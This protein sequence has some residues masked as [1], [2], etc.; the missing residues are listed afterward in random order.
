[1]A[2]MRFCVTDH[3]WIHRNNF[4]DAEPEVEGG[5]LS[6]GFSQDI[7]SMEHRRPVEGA[8]EKADFVIDLGWYPDEDPA[9]RYRLVLLGGG[10]D[11][12]LA[13]VESADRF[14]IRDTMERWMG[15]IDRAK[16]RDQLVRWLEKDA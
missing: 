2:L 16:H 11:D 6:S 9:G 15:Q 14:I 5:R 10:W 7:L 8:L 12:I 4:V 1:M 3:W 13:T